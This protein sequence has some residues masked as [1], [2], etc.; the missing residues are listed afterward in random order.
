MKLGLAFVRAN[1]TRENLR[2]ARQCGVTPVV[3]HYTQYDQDQ[4]KLPERF[5]GAW[6][7]TR[8]DEP[9][10]TYEELRD[11][12]QRINDEGLTLEALENFNPG[13]WYDILLDGPRKREQ[14]RM[15]ASSRPIIRPA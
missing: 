2:F 5:K 8:A 7:L 10:G 9:I 1:L 13:F 14:L 4:D 15:T 3:V 6:G 12:R 11:L